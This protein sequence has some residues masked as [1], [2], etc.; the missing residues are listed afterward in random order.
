L[1]PEATEGAQNQEKEKTMREIMVLGVMV[2]LLTGKL[3][4]AGGSQFLTVEAI[5]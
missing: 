3:Y 5:K 1:K 4:T 2:S